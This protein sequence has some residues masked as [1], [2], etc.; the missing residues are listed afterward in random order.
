[1]L[2]WPSQVYAVASIPFIL[3]PPRLRLR[4]LSRPFYA[5]YPAHLALLVL[6]RHLLGH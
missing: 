3:W 6:A 1:M 4:R 2:F 5:F